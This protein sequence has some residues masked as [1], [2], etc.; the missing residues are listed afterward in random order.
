MSEHMLEF[1]K[2]IEDLCGPKPPPSAPEEEIKEWDNSYRKAREELFHR[3]IKNSE[4]MNF[5][6]KAE[7][8]YLANHYFRLSQLCG[9]PELPIECVC[10]SKYIVYT[11]PV[12]RQTIRYNDFYQAY[13]PPYSGLLK[14]MFRCM[15]CDRNFVIRGGKVIHVEIEKLGVRY[16]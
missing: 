9:L 10:G 1:D 11:E 16:G 15:T 4:V 12:E 8:K 2:M 5:F 7:R 6:E 14:T 3:V 13:G